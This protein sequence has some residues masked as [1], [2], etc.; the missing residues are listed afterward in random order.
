MMPREPFGTED[1]IEEADL[2]DPGDPLEEEEEDLVDPTDPL[3]EP[4]E[5][6]DLEK[7]ELEDLLE[8]D[9]VLEKELQRAPRQAAGEEEP[10]EPSR[11]A[12][13]AEQQTRRAELKRRYPRSPGIWT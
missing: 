7:L 5:E 8:R 10:E 1:E 11:P 3:Y 9:R 12:A 13:S 6:G 2:S 4:E